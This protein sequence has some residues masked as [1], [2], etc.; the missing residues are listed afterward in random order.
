MKFPE[1]PRE[2]IRREDEPGSEK[3][4]WQPS[5]RCF[6]C[7]DTGIVRSRLAALVIRGFNPNRDRL[8]ICQAPGCN[9][10]A[11]WLYLEGNIDLR[12]TAAICQEFDRI[13]RAEWRQTTEQKFI[14]LKA[15]SQKL[16]MPGSHERTDHENREIQLKKAEI[17]A[18]TKEQW[19][20]Q[21]QKY[22]DRL[23][24]YA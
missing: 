1:L 16:A 14:N 21:G 23:E 3:E 19:M 20:A 13:S 18:I 22:F 7:E 12:L 9:A 2:P 24:E 15:L 6:C 4:I 11:K 17:E 10:S 8:P 5:W